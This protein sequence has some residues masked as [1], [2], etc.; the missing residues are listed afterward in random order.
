MKRAML[1]L[2]FFFFLH[3]WYSYLLA[4][5]TSVSTILKTANSKQTTDATWIVEK[6]WELIYINSCAKSWDVH[7]PHLPSWWKKKKKALGVPQLWFTR[8]G[9]AECGRSGE[10]VV[11][12]T[13]SSRPQK[14][15]LIGNQMS[16]GC[17]SIVGGFNRQFFSYNPE[18]EDAES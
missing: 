4:F 3:K 6:E 12:L 13:T 9:V 1:Y 11:G 10:N 18:D 5:H 16:L 17:Q 8:V 14:G 15:R 7:S 2:L